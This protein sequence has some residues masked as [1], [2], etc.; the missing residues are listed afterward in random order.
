MTEESRSARHRRG[1]RRA[2]VLELTKRQDGVVSFP[3]LYRL[4]ITRSQVRAELRAQRWRLHGSQ[5]VAMHNGPLSTLQEFWAAT[6][7]VGADAALDGVSALIAVGLT[8][9]DEGL[10]HVSVSKGT[11]YRRVRGVRIHET[12]RRRPGDVDTGGPPRVHTAVATI[13]AALWAR[14]NREAA[15]ILAMTV[16]QRLCASPDLVMAFATIRRHRRRTFIRDLL[17]DV[18]D[19][20]ESM[21]EL[22][23][24]TECR[25]RGIPPPT[26]QVRRVLRSGA[27]YLDAYWHEFGVVVEIE[28]VHHT[29]LDVAISDSLRQNELT[30]ANDAVL[31][32]P[33]LALRIAPDRVFEQIEALLRQ[34]GWTGRA[35]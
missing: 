16:Q 27:A 22:D 6:L 8:G 30:I 32:I 33:L 18:L 4:G 11:R 14:T 26:K 28:G 24:L 5:A 3:Q 23:F 12:R 1:A 13:R 19:G 17:T 31:R 35:A 7:N 34:R 25:R 2:E 20:A 29:R 15:L 21:G 10:I 9:F